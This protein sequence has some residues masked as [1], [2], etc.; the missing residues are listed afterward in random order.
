MHEEHRNADKHHGNG[1]NDRSCS[2]ET[3][4]DKESKAI[5]KKKRV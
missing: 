3:D 1:N 2:C 4:Y 5:M